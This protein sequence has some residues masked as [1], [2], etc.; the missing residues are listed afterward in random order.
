MVS[1]MEAV[2]TSET[3]DYSEITRR[4]IPEGAHLHGDVCPEKLVDAE[5]MWSMTKQHA[6][7][8]YGGR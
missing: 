1:V 6:L 3:S 2:C 4:C 8:A 5:M 7:M